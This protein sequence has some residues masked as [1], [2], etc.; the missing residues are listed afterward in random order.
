MQFAVK[1]SFEAEVDCPSSVAAVPCSGHGRCDRR[2][3]RCSC[4]D[5]WVLDSCEAQGVY[6]GSQLS[7]VSAP[8]PAVQK[9]GWA[10]WAVT[11]GCQGLGLDV[12]LHAHDPGSSPA[13]VSTR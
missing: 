13:L 6:P 2:T 8:L 12:A 10:Y 9:G 1:F 11:L 5:G 7:S 3:G 4:A